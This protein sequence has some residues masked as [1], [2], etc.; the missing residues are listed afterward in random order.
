MVRKLLYFY[1]SLVIGSGIAID[2]NGVI[3]VGTINDA[4]GNYLYATY[5]IKKMEMKFHV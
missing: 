1:K 3:Y 2:E 4:T 5:L